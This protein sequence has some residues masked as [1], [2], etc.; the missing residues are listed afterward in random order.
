MFIATATAMVVFFSLWFLLRQRFLNHALWF[1]F[2][3]YLFTRGF[4]QTIL[5]KH[6]RQ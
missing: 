4:V 5:F 6:Y 2:V 3:S 1:A